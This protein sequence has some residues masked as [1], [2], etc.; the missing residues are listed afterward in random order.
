MFS[1]IQDPRPWATEDHE[2]RRITEA[3]EQAELAE[4]ADEL[5]TTAGGR[6][7]TT[8][9]RSSASARRRVGELIPEFA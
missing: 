6:W 8:G 4:L 5:G 2:H 1:E 3:V 9:P 7:N